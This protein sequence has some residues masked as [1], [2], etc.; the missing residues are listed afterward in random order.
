[1]DRP[2]RR[3]QIKANMWCEWK[4]VSHPASFPAV[5]RAL[6]A[7]VAVRRNQGGP[8]RLLRN[9]SGQ[10]APEKCALVCMPFTPFFKRILMSTSELSISVQ[11]RF[12]RVDII[13][14]VRSVLISVIHSLTLTFLPK[15]H[16]TDVCKQ[17]CIWKCIS[18]GLLLGSV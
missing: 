16:H 14:S 5:L 11:P 1:M 17:H 8:E 6:G 7:C 10:P 3:A 2:F 12:Q 9:Y 18:V 4:C 13:L 15:G